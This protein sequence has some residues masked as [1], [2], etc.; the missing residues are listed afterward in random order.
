MNLG[1]F[2]YHNCNSDR[3]ARASCDRAGASFENA[4]LRGKLFGPRLLIGK[5]DRGWLEQ[6]RRDFKSGRRRPRS[7]PLFGSGDYFKEILS[8]SGPAGKMVFQKLS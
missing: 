7:F 6:M 4:G 1:Q 5:E 8:A 3:D 2:S